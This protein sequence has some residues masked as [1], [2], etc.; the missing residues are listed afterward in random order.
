MIICVYV[1]IYIYICICVYIYI[2]IERERER[3]IHTYIHTYTPE[4][5]D[6]SIYIRTA[7]GRCAKDYPRDLPNVSV[8]FDSEEI[9]WSGWN[10]PARC[11]GSQRPLIAGCLSLQSLGMDLLLLHV[12]EPL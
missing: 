11:S 8:C 6:V 3:E 1:C 10:C 12:S 4:A 2:Y 9:S 5:G 7:Q